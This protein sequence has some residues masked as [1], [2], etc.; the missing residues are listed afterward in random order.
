MKLA[1]RGGEPVRKKDFPG[2]PV[3][4]DSEREGLLRVLQSGKWGSLQGK[5]VE[6][7]EREFA[8][9]Q[10][11]E[12]AVAVTSGTT[13]L[14][15]AL[16]AAGIEALD[17]VIVPAYTFV[18]TATAV[19]S[20]AA[21]PVFADIDPD[22][23]NLDPAAFEN[24]ITERTRAVMPV[25][26]A[27]R[28]AD[29]DAIQK[30]AREHDLMIIEDAAQAWGAR[31]RGMSVGAIGDFGCFS[32]QSSKNITAGEGGIILTNDE[33]L[34]RL[35]RSYM[36]CGRMEGGI[37]YAHYLAGGNYR[38]TEFQAA[39]LRE[40]LKRYPK[41]LEIRRQNVA[42][43]N[44]LLRELPGIAP[45]AD[46]E[47]VTENAAHLYIFRFDTRAFDMLKK[48]D[49][50]QALQAEGIPCSGGYSMP[51]YEQP[52]FR[53][54]AFGPFTALLK[55]RIRCADLHLPNTE[56]ACR[57]EA[58]WIPQRVLLG[59]EEDMQDIARAVEKIYT[60]RHELV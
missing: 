59:T 31:W 2:W 60:N 54:L 16:R 26:F 47:R 41:Q 5:E 27:G 9:Y 11:A 33:E 13:A 28:P 57:S 36:N 4:N 23:Y 44:R 14:E 34:A 40:Q 53:N 48:E 50:I 30:I 21:V 18:A 35:A 45:L 32:F 49:F 6:S 10:G 46:D 58:V 1:I 12:N 43:L 22:S 39:I 24:A 25:H 55:N 51:L 3:W 52:L 19:L 15:V 29:M 56:R 42:L 38:M 20:L 37:W 7:F 17:E 8:A